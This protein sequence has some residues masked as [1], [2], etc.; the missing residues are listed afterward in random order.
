MTVLQSA[1]N[2]GNTGND[3]GSRG[4]QQHS[5]SQHRHKWEPFRR[6]TVHC[7]WIQYGCASCRGIIGLLQS[8]GKTNSLR[9]GHHCSLLGLWKQAYRLL[10]GSVALSSTVETGLRILQRGLHDPDTPGRQATNA[11]DGLC[12]LLGR[13]RAI[14]CC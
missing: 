5:Y 4:C 6:E 9:D 13:S 10:N 11:L 2:T 12:P 1:G 3:S 7:C 14:E 8:N